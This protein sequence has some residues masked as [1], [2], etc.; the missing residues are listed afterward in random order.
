MAFSSYSALQTAVLNWL[1]RPGDTFV[2]GSVPDMITLF[3]AEATRRLKSRF[4]EEVASLVTVAGTATVALPSDFGALRY[5]R[6]TSTNPDVPLVYMTPEELDSTWGGDDRGQPVNF[7]I[8]ETSLRLG[9]VPDAAYTISALYQQG[10]PALSDS[11]VS[12]WLLTNHPDAYLFGTLAEA[13]AF[14]GHDERF[15]GWLARRD[16]A[17]DSILL[18]DQ[19]A[20]WGGGALQIKTDVGN[21]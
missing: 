21:P 12:N 19:K 3:E 9:P 13:E 5:A 20:R 10:V 6:I 14:I 15:V 1:A 17:F 8:Q 16:A 18:A 2:S 11:N 7:T 4:A